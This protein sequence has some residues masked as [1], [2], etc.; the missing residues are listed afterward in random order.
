M[1]DKV[2]SIENKIILASS[3]IYRKKLLERLG[4]PFECHSPNIDESQFNGESPEEL[5]KRLTVHKAEAIALHHPSK[6]ILA[7]DQVAVLKNQIIGKPGSLPNAIKQ[8]KSFSGNRV[9]FLTGVTLRIDMKNYQNYLC[10]KTIVK[11][12]QLSRAQIERYLDKDLP[13]ECAGSFKVESLGIALFESVKTNDPTSLE[14]LPLI[15]VCR[16]LQEAGI[17]IP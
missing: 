12:R 7:S 15:A 14:G 4:I 2:T 9:E 6:L 3:S 5:V 8:L 1:I 10:S 17:D 13:L 11:F 16:F